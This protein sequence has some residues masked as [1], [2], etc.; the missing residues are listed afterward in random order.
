MKLSIKAP[1][2]AE[3]KALIRSTEK[4]MRQFFKN[5]SSAQEADVRFLFGPDRSGKKI[6]EVYLKMKDRNIFVTQQ[7]DSFESSATKAL[8]KLH[9][10]VENVINSR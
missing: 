9:Y 8:E 6:C 7:A 3:E 10:Q 5:H 1:S 4:V 2:H